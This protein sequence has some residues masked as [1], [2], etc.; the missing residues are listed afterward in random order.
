MISDPLRAEI[1]NGESLFSMGNIT[2]ALE[3][4]ESVL[5]RDPD[6]PFAR[7]NR[8][9]ALNKLRRHD[10]AIDAFCGTLQ[11]DR[12]NAVA[13]FNLI[14]NY[15][16]TRR[17]SEAQ[18]ALQ[19]YTPCLTEQDIQIF[20]NELAKAT[21]GADPTHNRQ[22]VF[23]TLDFDYNTHQDRVNR[24]LADRL[25]F[26][27]GVPK[28]GTTWLQHSLNGHPEIC[29]SG[30][31]DLT[32]LLE[33]V[34]NVTQQFNDFL[35]EKNR[36]IGTPDYP[37]FRS[38]DLKYLLLSAVGALFDGVRRDTH[39][40]CIGSKDPKLT[41]TMSVYADLLPNAKF[42]HIIRDGRDVLVSAWF[43]NLRKDEAATRH[44]WP[45]FQDFVEYGVQE[46]VSEISKT[47]TFAKQHVGRC[48]ELRY[49]GLH[50]D[51]R[52][53]LKALLEFLEVAPSS[54]M[55]DLCLQAGEFRRLAQGRQRGQEDR[56]AFFRKGIIGDWR[57]HFN[58]ESSDLFL[59]HAQELL[60]DL[61]YE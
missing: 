40:T 61:G 44:R 57:N 41:K 7:N 59:S 50:K 39:V 6:N 52:P 35:L 27:I 17:W 49:E 56:G 55:L 12:T 24:V 32:V 14:S 30:E 31:S 5:Q 19:T 28:S 54:H 2:E 33:H 25:F 34:C 9:V 43:N 46:W 16:V 42:I 26:V 22:E 45:Q 60:L 53:V 15:M 36:H 37:H 11:I 38:D 20:R 10:E 8:G 23:G 58:R 3:V 21:L 18:E 48:F 29:C 47:R 51:P 13:A 1:Q 4:F